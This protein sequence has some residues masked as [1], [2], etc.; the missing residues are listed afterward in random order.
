[1]KLF[2]TTLLLYGF[3]VTIPVSSE[4]K[5]PEKQLSKN[6][7]TVRW[8]HQNGRVFFEMKAPTSGWVAIGFNEAAELTGTYLLMG[9]ITDGEPL[10]AEHTVLS[11][12]DYRPMD[13][14][15]RPEVATDVSGE[16]KAGITTIRFSLPIEAI[17]SYRKPLGEGFQYTLLLAYSESDDFQHHSRMRT[18]LPITL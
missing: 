12:G 17:D 6:G 13:Q 5:E 4:S 18:S 11:P 8:Q 14:L 15:G 16:T 1:M 10:L 3:C 9:C 7:M 2:L